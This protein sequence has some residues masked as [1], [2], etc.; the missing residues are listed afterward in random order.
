MVR[1]CRTFVPLVITNASVI[2]RMSPTSSATVAEPFLADAAAAATA[3]RRRTS[4][5][6]VKQRPR[7]S[8]SLSIVEATI[9]NG[10]HHR[11][12]DE[13]VDR[14]AVCQPRPDITGCDVEARDR[15]AF[16]PPA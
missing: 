11:R 16:D 14:A 1:T 10:A 12:R 3:T 4:E 2:D 7:R 15:D 8:S 6:P 9:G 5:A 13:P